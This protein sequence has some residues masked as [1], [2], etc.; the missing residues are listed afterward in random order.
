M[1]SPVNRALSWSALEYEHTPKSAEWFFA[2]G[3]I[4]AA[5]IATGIFLR[6]FL[7]AGVVALAGLT[8]L[9]Y[10][11][12]RPRRIEVE[13]GAGGIRAGNAWYPYDELAAFCID[14]DG[15]RP[16]IT[17]KRKAFF[18]LLAVVPIEG[19]HPN[20]VRAALKEFLSE[21]ELREPLAQKILEYLGF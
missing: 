15:A 12:R 19:I 14:A 17:I 5:L 3:L 13:V 18:S 4:A 1:K 7:F 16:C 20:L 8:L 10:A 21:E 11:A 9:L 6:N 2:V